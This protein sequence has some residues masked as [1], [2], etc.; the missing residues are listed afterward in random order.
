MSRETFEFVDGVRTYRIQ[1]DIMAPPPP[2][3]QKQELAKSR[4]TPK[5]QFVVTNIR[6]TEIT[7]GIGADAPR[8]NPKFTR[9]FD[10]LAQAR[11]GA[12][13]YAKRIVREQMAAKPPAKD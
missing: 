13:E 9:G 12:G 4:R 10:T 3:F 1:F 7:K 6:I 11:T 5:P 8:K 2:A